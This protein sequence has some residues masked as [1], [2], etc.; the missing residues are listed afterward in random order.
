MLIGYGEHGKNHYNVLDCLEKEGRIKI[1]SVVDTDESKLSGLEKELAFTDINTAFQKTSPDIVAIVTNTATHKDVINT[2]LN[3]DKKP[4]LF[5]EKPITETLED[6]HS[7][8]NK[9]KIYG[10]GTKIPIDF[11]YLIRHSP[12][13]KKAVEYINDKKL[14][15]KGFEVKW[16]KKRAPLRPSPGVHIDE[17]THAIDIILNYIL[18]MTGNKIYNVSLNH[19]KRKYSRAFIDLEK[20]KKIYGDSK[21]NPIGEIE[22]KAVCG[23]FPVNGLSSFIREPF[24]RYI[25]INCNECFINIY[26]DYDKTD[27][28]QV[29]GKLKKEII[30]SE[31]YFMGKITSGKIYLEWDSFLRYFDENKKKKPEITTLDQALID[32]KI[33]E[34]MGNENL[35]LPYSINL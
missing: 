23:N 18:P 27:S 30:V 14:K 5:I 4:A 17:T 32:V 35:I 19:L 24:N 22:Y 2:I 6:A 20:Q 8:I 34:A 33:T 31:N 28:F 10:Y 13:V 26:F 1:V 15:I 12:A 16:K 25:R 21:M 11:G 3:H 9:L 7:I 29:L